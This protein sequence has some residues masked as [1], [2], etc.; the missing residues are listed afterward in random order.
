MKFGRNFSNSGNRKT[1]QELFTK[2]T[3]RQQ[4]QKG[5]AQKRKKS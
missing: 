4:N 1:K 5:N 2:T 3:N